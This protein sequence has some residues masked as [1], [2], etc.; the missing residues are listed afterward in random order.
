MIA[1]FQLFAAIAQKIAKLSILPNVASA[2]VL[3][4]NTKKHQTDLMT[5]KDSKYT[6]QP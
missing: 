3:E 5:P 4:K 2:M 6:P 1:S